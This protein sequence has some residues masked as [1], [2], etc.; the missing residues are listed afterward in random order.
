MSVLVSGSI[1]IDNVKTQ[2]AAQ[3]NLLGGS[4][5]YAAIAASFFSPVGMVG[6]VGHDFPTEHLE[7]FKKRNINLEGVE[8]STGETFRW[9]GEYMED[10]NDRE[11]LSVAL[12]VLES[13]KPAVAE[14]QKAAT[15]VNLLANAHPLNQHSVVDQLGDGPGF[16]IADT[17]DLW[18]TI[19]RDRLLALL[20]RVDLLVIND[21]EARQLMDTTNLVAAG[22]RLCEMGPR[23]VIIKKGEHGA[24]LFGP[25]RFFASPAYP[26]HEV[27]D[28][29]GAGDSF[30]GSIAGYLCALG[31]DR[32]EFDDLAN[33]VARGTIIAGYTCESFS[34]HRLEKLS[35][36]EFET[37]LGEFRGFTRFE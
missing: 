8:F 20:R 22:R 25:H 17:M 15:T 28:P 3:E 7:L 36:E 10:M 4:A 35:R 29:T 32:F 5:S 27:H 6:V 33:A 26:L 31:R 12:N 23:Y 2:K 21:S 24:L 30:V 13:W 16:T 18:I 34:T 37:R 19:A 1:A 9:S 11:T 14:S